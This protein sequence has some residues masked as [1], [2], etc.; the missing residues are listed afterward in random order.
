MW[1]EVFTRENGKMTKSMVTVFFNIS[2]AQNMMANGK[3][4]SERVSEHIF[5]QIQTNMKAIGTMIS[6]RAWGHITIQ[7]ETF[8][9]VSGTMEN[10]TEKETTS[11][12]VE[13]RYIKVTGTREKNKD[14]G[15]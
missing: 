9:K 2:M 10:P 13:K 3:M 1:T 11:T 8:T 14:S 7:M 5:I 4:I 12:K 6:N 15:S